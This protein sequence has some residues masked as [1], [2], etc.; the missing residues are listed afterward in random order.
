MSADPFVT[1]LDPF[2]AA[3]WYK[4]TAH[5]RP[6]AGQAPTVD[7][8]QVAEAFGFEVVDDLTVTGA[9][10]NQMSEEGD[11][12]GET[13]AEPSNAPSSGQVPEG[14]GSEGAAP[15]GPLVVRGELCAYDRCQAGGVILP[16]GVRVTVGEARYHPGCWSAF[17]HPGVCRIR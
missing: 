7:A 15:S 1:K 11:R 3:G 4:V 12:Q 6:P 13:P 14:G 16:G 9:G 5:G 2:A 8:G 10:G 17:G